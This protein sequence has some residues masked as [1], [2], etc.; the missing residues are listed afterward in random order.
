MPAQLVSFALGK[1]AE[2]EF[3]EEVDRVDV[4]LSHGR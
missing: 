1:D 3:G 2:S 4:R